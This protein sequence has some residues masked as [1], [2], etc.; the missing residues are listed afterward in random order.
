MGP[1]DLANL[2]AKLSCVVPP[3]AHPDLL[4]PAEQGADA[5]VFRVAPDVAI[6]QSADFFPPMLP[7]PQVFGRIAAANVL[8]DIYACGARPVTAI[9]LLAVPKDEPADNVVAMLA[10]AASAVAEAGAVMV[11]GH[12]ILDPQIKFG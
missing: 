9:N 11:G 7:D 3:S 4:V 2:L 8:S 10:G 1:G 12:T 6:V 5:G